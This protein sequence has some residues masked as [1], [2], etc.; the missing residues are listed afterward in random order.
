MAIAQRFLAK[1]YNR[2]GFPLF[3]YRIYAL[4][5]DGDMMEGVSSEAASIAGHL[6]LG[7]LCWIYDNNNVSIEGHTD[8]AFREDVAMRFK[9]YGWNVQRVG[10]RMMASGL[11]NRFKTLLTMAKSVF[12][13]RRQS[14]R[15]R[16]ASQTGHGCSPR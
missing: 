14:H 4:C 3:D 12:D 6:S 5:S 10:M 16:R 2:E 1:R 13:H 15:L 8:L 11:R 9:G 7:N